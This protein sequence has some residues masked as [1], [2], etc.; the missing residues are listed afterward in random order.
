[1]N[2]NTSMWGSN[3]YQTLIGIAS[4]LYHEA[5]HHKFQQERISFPSLDEEHKVIKMKQE[6]CKKALEDYLDEIHKFHSQI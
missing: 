6:E 3:E 5:L 4:T 2:L 1:M